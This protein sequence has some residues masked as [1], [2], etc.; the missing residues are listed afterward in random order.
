MSKKF[1]QL[2]SCK[3]RVAMDSLDA[4]WT[5]VKMDYSI[6]A[7]LWIARSLKLRV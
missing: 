3:V 7:S 1:Y 2:N 5:L 6:L 4:R